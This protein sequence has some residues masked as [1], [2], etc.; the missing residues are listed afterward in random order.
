MQHTQ[1]KRGNYLSIGK[2]VRSR[3]TAS[4]Y[5]SRLDGGS[6]GLPALYIIDEMSSRLQF[7]LKLDNEIQPGRHFDIIIGTGSGG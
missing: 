3:S 2:A 5:A 1:R 4:S 6:S 7:D